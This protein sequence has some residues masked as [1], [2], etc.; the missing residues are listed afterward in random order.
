MDENINVDPEGQPP[1]LEKIRSEKARLEQFQASDHVS[2]KTKSK[3]FSAVSMYGVAIDFG[4]AL[5][6]PLLAG[7]YLGKWLNSKFSTEWAI[8]ACILLALLVSAVTIYK[9]IL[10]LKVKMKF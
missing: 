2:E 10:R 3:M 8:P 6:I 4:L 9:Q 7:I 5:F 1:D